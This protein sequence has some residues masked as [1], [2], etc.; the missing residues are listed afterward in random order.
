MGKFQDLS[1]MRFERLTVIEKDLEKTKKGTIY[2]KC[3]CE[4]GNIISVSST[5]LK[6]GH[7][8]S[9]GCLKN[10][11]STKIKDL[12]NMKF[13]RLT[14]IKRDFKKEKEIE[15]SGKRKRTYWVCKCECG[16]ITTVETSKLTS[17]HTQSCGCIH[18]EVT[19]S[20]FDEDYTGV[21]WNELTVLERDFKK[22]NSTDR[23]VRY[24]KCKCSCGNIISIPTTEVKAKRQISC[25]C[26]KSKGEYV[27]SV[28]LN[29]INLNYEIQK[30][31]KDL[32]GVGN[33]ELLYD[34]YLP[35]Y[36][37]L[38]EFQG[39]Q[40]EKPQRFPN[41]DNEVKFKIQ[42]EHDKRKRE[43]TKDNNIDL[44]EIWYYDYNNIEEILKNKLNIKGDVK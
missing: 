36:N 37:L 14:V 16:N 6:S 20:K 26:V 13:G 38:I 15:L 39:E 8:K 9:C 30:T 17:N 7:T 31:Y 25:G 11:P 18:S 24:W 2:W 41:C 27:I 28:Y 44:L 21:K 1:G 22:E 10:K 40:H 29:K 33:G 34:F 5:H 42:Q 12:T 43:Y 4:C 32:I 23:Q 35:D 3:K 19:R